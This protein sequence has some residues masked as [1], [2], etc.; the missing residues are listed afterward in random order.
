MSLVGW[1]DWFTFWVLPLAVV[2]AMPLWAAILRGMEAARDPAHRA[3]LTPAWVFFRRKV[4]SRLKWWFFLWGLIGAAF[5]LWNSIEIIV[6]KAYNPELDTITW[7]ILCADVLT[8]GIGGY[9]SLATICLIFARS[10]RSYGG[11]LASTWGCFALLE[12]IYLGAMPILMMTGLA[13]SIPGY[14]FQCVVLPWLPFFAF[15]I[16]I[17]HIKHKG[18]DWFQIEE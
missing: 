9:F 10:I 17:Q 6:Y 13:N 18:D 4:I 5:T 2:V 15:Y 16:L 12:G 11:L 7:I 3:T 8:R 14:I 1:G